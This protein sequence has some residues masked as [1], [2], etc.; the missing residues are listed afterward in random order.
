MAGQNKSG[1]GEKTN[2]NGKK[3]EE[4]TSLINVLV[5][6]NYFVTKNGVVQRNGINIGICASQKDIYP[7]IYGIEYKDAFRFVSKRLKPDDAFYNNSN[8]TLY[9]IEKKYQEG[10]GSVDEKLLTSEYKELYY[11][12][13]ASNTHKCQ[14]SNV[15]MIYILND[16]FKN[17]CYKDI[18]D[19]MIWKKCSV[20]FNRL[21]LSLLGLQ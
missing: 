2:L 4:E 1:G 20:A 9:I 18:I 8:Q 7:N 16:Y 10:K 3:F 5:L 13:I 11:K 6:N 21:D 15:K 12:K 14:I 19:Y 17:E